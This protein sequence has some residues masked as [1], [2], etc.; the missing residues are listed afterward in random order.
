MN[1][2][3]VLI[4]TGGTGSN[5][6]YKSLNTKKNLIINFLINLYDDGKI[7]T[8]V[9]YLQSFSADAYA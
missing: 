9:K 4:V 5:F 1:I 7:N 8:G 3:K 2:K 6:L